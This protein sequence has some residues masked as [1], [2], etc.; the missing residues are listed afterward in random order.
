MAVP[1]AE[2]DHA[3]AR[4]A[5]ASGDLVH[6]AHHLASALAAD[7]EDERFL[8]LA[9]ALAARA[10]RDLRPLFPER[11][12]GKTYYA[13]GALE[14]WIHASRG[15]ATEALALLVQVAIARPEER[16]L[17][18]AGRWLL[19]DGF[20]AAVQP[21]TFAATLARLRERAELR[22][23]PRLLDE[24]GALV[25]HVARA[26]GSGELVVV[27]ARLLRLHG[28]AGRA[29]ALGLEVDAATPSYGSA[30]AAAYAC[31][32]L[33]RPEEALIWFRRA[34]SRAPAEESCRM[35]IA[36]TLTAVGRDAEALAVYE[37]TLRREPRHPWALPSALYLRAALH[38]EAAAAGAL[39]RLA[40]DEPENER[41][42]DRAARLVAH[43]LV[44][45][46]GLP[47]L[48]HLPRRTEALLDVMWKILG[49]AQGP[50]EKPASIRLTLSALEPPSAVAA[51][52]RQLEALGWAVEVHLHVERLQAPDPRAPRR[53]GLRH[54]FRRSFLLWRYDGVRARPAVAAPPPERTAPVAA[55]ARTPYALDA[56]WTEAQ[57]LRPAADATPAELA[58][59]MVHPPPAPQGWEWA[60]WLFAVQVAAALLLA[61]DAGGRAILEDLLYGPLDWAAGAAALALARATPDD[62][63]ARARRRSELLAL[64]RARPS[65]GAWC[66]EKPLLAAAL[67]LSDDP[68]Q[69]RDLETLLR[70]G[71]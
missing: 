1:T 44:P 59:A 64:V 63:A 16:W 37:D 29:L 58:A 47:Y 48:D 71:S 18:W 4:D 41:A 19:R 54:W 31:R 61:Q 52:H 45:P 26:T 12:D 21:L 50:P 5:F 20:A 3:L 8:R 14:A 13:A 25:G 42:R 53:R 60:E 40:E 7:L 55:L 67:R 28:Q 17:S 32:E 24:L 51:M 70:E 66:L 62:P 38:G 46:A 36:D 22:D 34:S 6:A 68:G 56:W 69:R 39:R 10:P 23:A 2:R 57:R 49:D 33:G 27:A 43:G 65:H 11:K 15:E 30:L 9:D 35:D